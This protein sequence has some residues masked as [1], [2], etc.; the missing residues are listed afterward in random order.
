MTVQI[1]IKNAQARL[2]VDEIVRR[3]GESVTEAITAALRKRLS[4]LTRAEKLARVQ[5]ISQECA[6]LWVEPWKSQD[7]G[8]LL[9]D[10]QGLPK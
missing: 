2:L 4:E 5:A 6:A 3:T 9:Y 7:H 8:D 1:N 10:D